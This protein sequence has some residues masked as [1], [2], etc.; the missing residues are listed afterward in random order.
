MSEEQTPPLKVALTDG[1]G[2][3]LLRFDQLCTG[4]RFMLGAHL[5]TKIGPEVAR[6]HGQEGLAL[7][8]RGY[9]YIGDHICTFLKSDAV[10]FVPPNVKL[11]SERSESALDVGLGEREK[12]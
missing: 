7:G 4:D 12:G 6:Q 3:T 8:E 5:W 2:D 9:G 10:Q 11:T 1:L